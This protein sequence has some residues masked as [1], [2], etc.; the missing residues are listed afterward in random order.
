MQK[1]ERYRPF[2]TRHYTLDWLTSVKLKEI[3]ALR[4]DARIA[5]AQN[6]AIDTTIE[7]SAHYVN[8]AMARVLS[9]QALL[10]AVSDWHD[11]ALVAT[12]SFDNFLP[13]DSAATIAVASMPDSDTAAL[14]EVVPRMLGF[15][16]HELGLKR[17]QAVHIVTDADRE[18]FL[19]N[20][21]APLPD[22]S[23]LLTAADIMHDAR[24]E[25]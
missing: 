24:Y 23:L 10:Y 6:R 19:Q 3:Y 13:D 18:V 20:H 14:A 4:S 15:A 11:G 5:A 8:R 9:D 7:T 25:Y 21:F 17:L 22:G 16:V 1:F 12:L 2:M